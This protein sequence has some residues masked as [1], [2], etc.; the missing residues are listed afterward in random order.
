MNTKKPIASAV[1]VLA[2]GF[3]VAA[4]GGAGESKSSGNRGLPQGSEPVIL[5]PADFT[6]KIDNRY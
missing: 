1:G 2:A 4:F 5:N 3:A 6:T